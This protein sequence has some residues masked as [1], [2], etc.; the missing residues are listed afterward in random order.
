MSIITTDNFI[1]IVF[2]EAVR[3]I[4]KPDKSI[5]Y[6]YRCCGY[7][8]KDPGPIMLG[9]GEKMLLLGLIRRLASELPDEYRIEHNAGIFGSRIVFEEFY[10]EY[11]PELYTQG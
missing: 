5:T 7:S 10:P 4:E 2:D 8:G 1:K 3:Y 6:Y 11:C 9:S